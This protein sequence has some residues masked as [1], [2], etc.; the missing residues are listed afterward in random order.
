MFQINFSAAIS[1]DGIQQRG[2]N[3]P[4][5]ALVLHTI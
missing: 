1:E 3:T 2:S 5:Q 4:T